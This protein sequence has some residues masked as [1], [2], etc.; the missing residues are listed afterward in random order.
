[1]HF[2]NIAVGEIRNLVKSVRE[3]K[4]PVNHKRDEDGKV[5][6]SVPTINNVTK[7]VNTNKRMEHWINLR[8]ANRYHEEIVNQFSSI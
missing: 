2:K 4:P 6:S 8:L 3:R 1:L 7:L 5:G